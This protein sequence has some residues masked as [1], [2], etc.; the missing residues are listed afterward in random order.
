[1]KVHGR[2]IESRHADRVGSQQGYGN[3][4][5]VQGL[6]DG[7]QPGLQR[8]RHVRRLVPPRPLVGWLVGDA[9][10]LDA[11]VALL[12]DEVL[13]TGGQTL[14]EIVHRQRAAMH[15][16]GG[17]ALKLRKR[18]PLHVG[19]HLGQEYVDIVFLPPVE[20]PVKYPHFGI[21][22]VEPTPLGLVH[23]LLQLDADPIHSEPLGMTIEHP[24]GVI[25]LGRRIGAPAAAAVVVQPEDRIELGG[26]RLLDRVPRRP[27][28]APHRVDHRCR[29]HGNADLVGGRGMACPRNGRHDQHEGCLAEAESNCTVSEHRTLLFQLVGEHKLEVVFSI[30][31]YV[32]LQIGCP[33][34]RVAWGQELL[35]AVRVAGHHLGQAFVLRPYQ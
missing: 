28:P 31:G 30:L 5:R 17:R 18:V 34:V 24:P 32:G 13:N 3:L 11:S 8:H 22:P 27:D 12:L 4:L 29:V 35:G 1:M 10:K 2:R 19:P 20:D 16:A 7:L 15:Y 33:R 23:P 21:V 25:V 14:G 9:Q 6:A 26:D